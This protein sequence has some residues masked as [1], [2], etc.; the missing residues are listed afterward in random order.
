[1][2]RYLVD[3]VLATRRGGAR[4]Q[5]YVIMYTLMGSDGRTVL[6]VYERARKRCIGIC[7]HKRNCC[8]DNNEIIIIIFEQVRAGTGE[9][10]Q[11]YDALIAHARAY[12]EW[13]RKCKRFRRGIRLCKP[14]LW[15]FYTFILHLFR[16]SRPRAEHSR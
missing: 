1:M 14:A 2:N 3:H 5:Y 12:G 7:I 10:K 6:V 9:S 16:I 4:S 8:G 13:R 11:T 15:R